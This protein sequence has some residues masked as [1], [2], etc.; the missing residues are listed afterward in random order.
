MPRPP[1]LRDTIGTRDDGT[2]ETRA[3]RIVALIRLGNYQAT[4][5]RAAGVDQSTFYRWLEK[6]QEG[7]TREYRE[8]SEAVDRA[9]AEAE[10]H[11]VLMVRTGMAEDWR[12]AM[13]FLER[14]FPKRWGRREAIEVSGPDGGVIEVRDA[15]A[16]RLA[17]SFERFR[18]ERGIEPR[19]LEPPPV[20]GDDD[21]VVD[22]E[23]VEES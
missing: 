18:V 22:A 11:A 12:A 4:A 3:D 23:V 14:A 7:R 6:G 21:E 13:T 16:T 10:S 19:S 20:V 9:R 2:P 8:F 15:E 17:A 1:K 5:A